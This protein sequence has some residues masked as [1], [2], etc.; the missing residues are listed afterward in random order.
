[1]TTRAVTSGATPDAAWEAV[2]EAVSVYEHLEAMPDNRLQALGLWATCHLWAEL[3]DEVG[4]GEEVVGPRGQLAEH[5]REV[6]AA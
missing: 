1:M 5:Q 4:R 3:L 2:E 6:D